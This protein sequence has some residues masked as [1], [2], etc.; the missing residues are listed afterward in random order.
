MRYPLPA[1]WRITPDL[2]EPFDGDSFW[3]WVDRG[4]DD[5]S[6]WHVRLRDVFAPD[7]GD[8]G[9]LETGTYLKDWLTGHL[10]GTEW[11][12]L[13]ETFRTPR[14]DADVKTL[15]RWV[16][17]VTDAHGNSLNRDVASWISFMEYPHGIGWKGTP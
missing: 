4:D 12:Y 1:R 3:A 17:I 2:S 8:A 14:S 7:H 11:P 16:G 10:D 6:L 13:L 15:S 9:Y 5:R